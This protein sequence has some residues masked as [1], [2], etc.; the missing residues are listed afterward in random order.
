MTKICVVCGNEKRY[1]DYHRMYRLCDLCNNKHALK[2]YFNMKDKRLEK[3]KNHHHNK[4]EFFSEQNKK[5][6]IKI[7]DL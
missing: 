5:R 6:K 7:T 4:K 2:Q 1:D 3:M